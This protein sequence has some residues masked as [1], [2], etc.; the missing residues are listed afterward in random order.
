MSIKKTLFFLFII[1]LVS[2]CTKKEETI[3]KNENAPSAPHQE[4]KGEMHPDFDQNTPVSIPEGSRTLIPDIVKG[5]WSAVKFIVEDKKKNTM[6]EYK[7]KVGGKMSIPDSNL[8]IKVIDF[9]P[10]LKIEDNPKGSIFTSVSN[11]LNNPATHIIV[12][13]EGKEIFNG[14]LFSLFPSIHPF[15]H[16]SF[17]VVLKEGIPS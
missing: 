12:L 17:G 7:I 10:D 5:K 8:V 2:G 3:S 16:D 13:E 6:Q 1:I 15:Q 4:S 9:L 14:W 11:D